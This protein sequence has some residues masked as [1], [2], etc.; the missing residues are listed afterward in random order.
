MKKIS[1]SKIVLFIVVLLA[2]PLYA[3]SLGNR[4]AAD[5]S[6]SGK[7]LVIWTYDSFDSEWGPGPDVARVFEEKTGIKITWVSP[8]DAGEIVSRL[9]LEG[10]NA[11]ADI[12]LGVDQ[13]LAP[14]VLGSGLLEAYRPAGAENIFSELVLDTAFRLTPF[15]YSYFA[16]VYDSEK[17]P[18]PPRSLEELTAPQYR[19]SL[20]LLD[21]RTSSPGLGFFSW[22]K[23]VYGSGWQDYWRRLRPSILTVAEGWS[24]GYGLFTRGEAPLVLSYTTSPAYHLEYEDTER[25]KAA[26]FTNGHPLQIE[27]AG[28]LAAARNK[29]NAKLFLDFMLSND[30]Q[31]IIPLTNW[32][33]PVIDL[34]L[35]SSFRINPKSDRPLLPGPVSEAELNEW[36]ALMR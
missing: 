5:S 7:E 18:T 29:D 13:N 10:R 14:R 32:M 21:P 22:V 3:F 28:L 2:L 33:Y 27:V 16:I 17:L 31:S 1:I 6:S 26:I 19:Q 36:A 35:P 9:L 24:S 12:I 15:D 20:I 30:F 23:E 25:Y 11:G 4:Q 34:P 8:G